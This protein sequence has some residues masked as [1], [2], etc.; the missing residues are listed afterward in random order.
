VES[1]VTDGY[2]CRRNRA[3]YR[4]RV[5]FQKKGPLISQRPGGAHKIVLL[6]DPVLK[7]AQEKLDTICQNLPESAVT[8]AGAEE[9]Q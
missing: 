1:A 8:P 9:G 3:R 6:F 4:R 2:A 5:V 7:N